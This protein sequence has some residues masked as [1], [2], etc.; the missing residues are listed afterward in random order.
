[1]HMRLTASTYSTVGQ[2]AALHV[3]VHITL[4]EL[5]YT[6]HF[7]YSFAAVDVRGISLTMDVVMDPGEGRGTETL[8]IA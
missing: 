5:V 8:R 4:G 2:N 3:H 6:D 7:Y 1:M